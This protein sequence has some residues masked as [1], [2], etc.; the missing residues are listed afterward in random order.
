MKKE[1]KP[2]VILLEPPLFDC[3]APHLGC[4]Q[5]TVALKSRNYR[6]EYRDLNIEGILWLFEPHR[7]RKAASTVRERYE[8]LMEKACAVAQTGIL[9]ETKERHALW[10]CLQALQAGATD[11]SCA[12]NAVDQLR[13]PESFFDPALHFAA[14][15]IIDRILDLH[16]FAC[17]PDLSMGLC[18]QSYNGPYRA[19]SLSDLLAAS[20]DQK[21]NPF[22]PCYE[23]SVLPWVCSSLPLIVGISISNVYQVIPGLALSRLLHD[24]GLFVL[25]GGA[26]FSKFESQLL[27]SPRFFE[28]CDAVAI[29]EGEQTILELVRARE[30]GETLEGVPNLILRKEKS[31]IATGKQ[32]SD[33]LPDFGS[34]DFTSL[35]LDD[36][37]TPY[38]VLPIHAGK[39]CEWSKCTFCE[40]PQINIDFGRLRRNRKAE[41][42][43]D[44]MQIQMERHNVRHFIFTDEAL[45]VFLLNAIADE[46]LRRRTEVNYIGYARFTTGFDLEFCTKLAASGCRKLMF[47]LESGSV[48][49]NDRCRKGVEL[50]AVPGIIRNCQQSGIAVHLFTIVGLPGETGK[51]LEESE[52]YLRRLVEVIDFPVSTIDVSALYLNWNSWLRRNAEKEDIRYTVIQDFPLHADAYCFDSGMDSLTASEMASEVYERLCWEASEAGFPIGYVNPVW[53]AWEEYTLLY[54][55]EFRDEHARRGFVWPSSAQDVLHRRVLVAEGLHIHELPFSLISLADGTCRGEQTFLAAA[56]SSE[57]VEIDFQAFQAIIAR[58][59]HLVSA[60]L[61]ELV[62]SCPSAGNRPDRYAEIVQWIR[63]GILQW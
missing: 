41:V 38:P 62:Q 54:L 5:L 21:G 37:F 8:Q 33:E 1:L 22:F 24:H 46:I 31:V 57:I 16:A 55:S 6:V 48:S 7:V 17:D 3:R 34:A 61:E 63:A 39:G 28:M 47:G 9:L 50:D 58:N 44:E 27:D 45:P 10:R 56:P 32:F 4:A 53:P 30:R 40:I 29:G 36:Y 20:L 18:P 11:P 43:V 12:R 49:V 42:I 60:L 52:R 14:R 51:Y 19:T 59:E 2:H 26:F 13:R 25:I 23:Q 35:T 15:K